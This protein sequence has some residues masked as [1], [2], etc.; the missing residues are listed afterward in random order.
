MTNKNVYNTIHYIIAMLKAYKIKNIIDER[1]AAYVATGLAYET[2]EP[3][4][5]TCTGATA[6]RNYLSALTEAYYKNLP[7]IALTFFD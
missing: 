2:Q 3:V 6:S 7:I 4:V 1:S 5:I